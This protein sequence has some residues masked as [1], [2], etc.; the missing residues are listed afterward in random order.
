MKHPITLIKVYRYLCI[1]LLISSLSTGCAIVPKNSEGF[2]TEHYYSCGPKALEK[3]LDSFFT[4]HNIFFKRGISTKDIS[5]LI[6]NNG[7]ALQEFLSIFNQEALEI[8]W[9]SQIKTALKKYNIEV[10]ELESFSDLRI[11]SDIAIVLIHTKLTN[12][13]WLCFPVDKNINK[14]WG[15]KTIVDKIYLLR[16]ADE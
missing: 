11:K 1:L 3:A 2:Y 7:F 12:Y 13:H 4:K 10:T 6:Q 16:T 14:Y 8:T 9:P 5:K 15:D